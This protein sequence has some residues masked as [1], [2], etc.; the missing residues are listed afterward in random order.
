MKLLILVMVLGMMVS[1]A[2]S[3]GD[4]IRF[5]NEKTGAEYGPVMVANGSKVRVGES[6]LELTAVE[7]TEAQKAL[8][9]KMRAITITELVLGDTPVDGAAATLR[10][11]A[12]KADPDKRGVN[13]VVVQPSGDGA[14]RPTPCLSLEL[15][16]ISL[17]DAL[18]YSCEAAG[19]SMRIDDNA[20][21]I[22]LDPN[23]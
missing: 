18:W 7:Q 4:T 2:A 3:A 17:S 15:R 22:S 13:I 12:K 16:N 9:K 19:L 20:V 21:V 14:A 1:T 8:E 6:T 23:K 10:D 5:R 11:H